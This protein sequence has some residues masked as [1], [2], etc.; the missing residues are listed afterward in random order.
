MKKRLTALL[1]A[2]TLLSALVV[3]I[4]AD[5]QTEETAAET[6]QTTPDAAGTL[7]FGNL[8]A[9]MRAESY[10]LL[11]LEENIAAIE[12]M[13][14]DKLEEE[15]R[16]KLNETADSQWK[17]AQL[18]LCADLGWAV[19]PGSLANFFTARPPVPDLAAFE[20]QL[21]TA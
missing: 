17:A 7:S 14:Y 12:S 9:R 5:E 6:A 8:G 2:L 1:L 13:D 16:D 18:R 10:S 15:L 19:L 3:G 4:A 20:R 21:V 11:V